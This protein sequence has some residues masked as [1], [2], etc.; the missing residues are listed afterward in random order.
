MEKM[1]A[2]EK[3]KKKLDMVFDIKN[4]SPD[5]PFSRF[6]WKVYKS[7]WVDPN[8]YF[9]SWFL[10]TANG[11]MIENSQNITM[12]YGTVFVSNEIIDKILNKNQHLNVL[13]FSHHPL[14]LESSNKW[15][16][17]ISEDRLK[18]LQEKKI[19]IYVV[20]T[21]LDISELFSP[22]KSLADTF[23]LQNQKKYIEENKKMVWIIGDLT[24][25]IKFEDFLNIIQEKLWISNIYYHKGSN[26]VKTIWILAGWWTNIKY[27]KDSILWGCD[28]YLTWDYLNNVHDKG[29]MD[30]KKEM[31]DFLINCPINTIAASHYATEKNVMINEIQK[32][33][34]KLGIGY[35]FISQDN[36]W[37]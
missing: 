34:E 21:P 33:F 1:I 19:S 22:S 24:E 23:W 8:K 10:N 9:T 32:F 14:A 6:F 5:M 18:K 13:I 11:M 12:V 28:T 15:F 36:P 4:S 26:Y 17:P 2:I 7:I 31:E 35:E 20:H 25:R 16:L 37:E 3:I 27:V 29:C 30:E